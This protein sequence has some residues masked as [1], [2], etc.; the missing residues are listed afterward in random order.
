MFTEEQ[1]EIL[2]AALYTLHQ[3]VTSP[4]EKQKIEDLALYIDVAASDLTI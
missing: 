2:L 4:E 3:E 1:I